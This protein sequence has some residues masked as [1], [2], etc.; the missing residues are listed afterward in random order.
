L[1]GLLVATTVN[2][3]VPLDVFEPETPNEFAGVYE[4]KV[5]WGVL[6]LLSLALP[7]KVR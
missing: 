3:L 6:Q 7:V 2:G 4:F 5:V 1:P